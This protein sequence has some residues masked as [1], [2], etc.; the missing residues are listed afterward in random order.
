MSKHRAEV[1]HEWYT[2]EFDWAARAV[3]FL[4]RQTDESDQQLSL[5]GLSGSAWEAYKHSRQIEGAD[6]FD[7]LGDFIYRRCRELVDSIPP[8]ALPELWRLTTEFL[9]RVGDRLDAEEMG[10][11]VADEIWYSLNDWAEQEPLGKDWS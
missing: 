2:E 7:T 11:A 6:G 4:L 9:Y 8:S 1:T 5:L 10:E 3:I